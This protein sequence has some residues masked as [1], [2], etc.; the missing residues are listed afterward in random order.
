MRMCIVYITLYSH[1]V[2]HSDTLTVFTC[3]FLSNID[4]ML[5]TKRGFAYLRCRQLK[6]WGRAEDIIHTITNTT[7]LARTFESGEREVQTEE[8]RRGCHPVTGRG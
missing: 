5:S 7:D 4:N 8:S 6:C 2:N 3:L 1:D